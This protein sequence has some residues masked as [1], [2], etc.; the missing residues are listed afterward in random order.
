MH[1]YNYIKQYD[2]TEEELKLI[3]FEINLESILETDQPLLYLLES[4]RIDFV[5]YLINTNY[6]K[7]DVNETD[8]DKTAFISIVDYYLSQPAEDFKKNYLD[9]ENRII[10]LFRR[11]YTI[12][13]EDKDFIKAQK[14]ITDP[15]HLKHLLFA[16][17]ALKLNSL[18]SIFTLRHH[19]DLITCLACIKN[20]INIGNYKSLDLLVKATIRRNDYQ[21]EM[22]D[23]IKKSRKTQYNYLAKKLTDERRNINE[24]ISDPDLRTVLKTLFY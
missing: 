20:D 2:F 15:R 23:Y 6:L 10:L 9:F 8:Q 12:K 3:N 4:G 13:N 16:S 17:Y 19:M 7:F 24:K 11:G 14:H 21:N 18:K 1:D 5:V 22:I